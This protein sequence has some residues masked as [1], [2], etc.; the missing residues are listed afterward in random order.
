MYVCMY[1]CMYVVL[2]S[3]FVVLILLYK[4]KKSFLFYKRKMMK[5]VAYLI[6][7]PVIKQREKVSKIRLIET[8]L[9]LPKIRKQKNKQLI[10]VFQ[11]C[12]F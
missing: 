6:I 10:V 11:V 9:F 1:V 5:K 12:G 8:F 2:S 7:N 3:S 4:G